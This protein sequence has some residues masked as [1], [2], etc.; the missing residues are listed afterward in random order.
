MKRTD[1]AV[2]LVV[3]S[4]AACMGSADDAIDCSDGRCDAKKVKEIRAADE[5]GFL[6]YL[7]QAR[8][9]AD[10]NIAAL[11]P[12]DILDGPAFSGAFPFEDHV[13]CTFNAEETAEQNGATPKF[14]CDIGKDTFKVKYGNA[15]VNSE[16]IVTRLFFAL[17]F[18]ADGDYSVRVTCNGCPADIQATLAETG[19]M[20]LIER[21]FPAIEIIPDGTQRTIEG[22]RMAEYRDFAGVGRSDLEQSVAQLEALQLLQAFVQHGDCKPEQQRLV[23]EESGVTLAGANIDDKKVANDTAELAHCTAPVALIQDLGS[24]LGDGKLLTSKLALQEWA[25]V[26]VFKS[27][28]GVC[29]ADLG[30][31]ATCALAGGVADPVISE[32]GRR[33]L[34]ERIDAMTDAQ[35]LA[36]FQAGRVDE[37]AF[38]GGTGQQWVAAFRAKVEQMRARTCT[39]RPLLIDAVPGGGFARTPDGKLSLTTTLAAFD[40]DGVDGEV[41]YVLKQAGKTDI[42]LRA[43][44]AAASATRLDRAQT[45]VIDDEA[46]AC[47]RGHV[48]PHVLE[49]SIVD[50]DGTES[51]AVRS[52][53]NLTTVPGPGC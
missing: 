34:V 6:R 9:W 23:C 26:P 51:R 47:V 38:D 5:A 33:F 11:T 20:A 43:P 24:T 28:T 18:A 22:W 15:E 16:A 13:E 32:S 52:Q 25:A 49:I 1:L 50:A 8:V 48:G 4:S 14:A 42:V 27:G 21:K 10:P 41:K 12:D 44:L 19:G 46:D 35:L 53:V 40:A 17:G 2:V 31:N 7:S 37:I 30:L 45:I 36:I 29:R 39:E 3:A